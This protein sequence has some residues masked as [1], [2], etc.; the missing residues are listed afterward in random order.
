MKKTIYLLFAALAVL[1][2]CSKGRITVSR[3]SNIEPKIY[4]DYKGVTVPSNIAP[5]D[6]T[7]LGA[8]PCCLIVNGKGG[9]T[10]IMGDK[11]LF[12][13]DAKEWKSLLNDNKGGRL[14]LTVAIEKDGDWTALKPF[15]I[16]VARE[17]IDPYLSYR[18]IP[19]GYEGW[20]Y[21]GIYQRN[22][23]NYDQ[24]PIFENRMAG[25]NCVNCHSYCNGNPDKM[26]FHSR[27]N[28]PGTV[29]IQGSEIEKLNTKTDST[30]SALVYPYW[31]P[32][33][34]YVAFAVNSTFQNFY[35]TSRDRIEV[36]D[37][38][39]DVVVYDVKNHQIAY[40]PL[41]KSPQALETFP[42]FSPDGRSLYFCSA[43]AL[44]SIPKTI[45]DVKY[46]LCRIDFNPESMTFGT[47]VDTLYNARTEGRSV[48][49]PRVSPNGKWLVFVLHKFGTFSIWH[50]DA[51]L[52]AVNLQTK[53]VYPLAAA[54]SND[55][56]SYHSWS[57]NSHWMV[58]SSRRD[59][60]LF[61]RPYI[62]YIDNRGQARKPFMLP[63][64]NPKEYYER[65]MYSYNIPELMVHKANVGQARIASTL[66][67][68]EGTNVTVRKGK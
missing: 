32:S 20:M 23:E 48:S 52:Y 57:R 68:S 31:H 29:M 34:K 3:Q 51:D 61:T 49:L 62:T 63:Q 35:S 45:K 11:G 27:A 66:R 46:S 64:R 56:E 22:L 36:Y 5:L 8:E 42:T 67:N 47:T 41:T 1:S 7:Y 50:K 16:D 9:E 19:P 65:L 13:F 6:F 59:D 43:K 30:I 37:K 58:F 24:T 60:G 21:M 38:E 44:D 12:E 55:V 26:L 25:R 39:S 14:K 10:Q 18:L 28:F 33:G 53:K 2:A 15:Y 4:P 17:S 54:N 40:S